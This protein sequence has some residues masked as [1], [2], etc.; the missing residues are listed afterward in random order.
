MKAVNWPKLASFCIFLSYMFGK[1]SRMPSQ[2][3]HFETVNALKSMD[4]WQAERHVVRTFSHLNISRLR[5]CQHPPTPRWCRGQRGCLCG[6]LVGRDRRDVRNQFDSEKSR[7][8]T[9]IYDHICVYM[10]NFVKHIYTQCA[11]HVV[12]RRN[13]VFTEG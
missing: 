4:I 5:P 8:H 11:I 1:T 12:G 7:L 3:P 2:F 13:A 9:Y 6:Q 10:Y